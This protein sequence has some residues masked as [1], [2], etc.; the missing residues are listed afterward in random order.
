MDVVVNSKA[1][2]RAIKE[3]IEQRSIQSTRI[4]TVVGKELEA[5][6][7]SEDAPIQ[8]SELMS[9]QFAEQ[10]P[11]VDDPEFIPANIHELGLSSRVISQEVPDSQIEFFYRKLHKLLDITLD[12]ASDQSKDEISESIKS[13][14]FTI[15]E[16]ND[17][18]E[19]DDD[20]PEISDEEYDSYL[21]G[22]GQDPIGDLADDIKE[23]ELR[24][25]Q[26]WIDAGML[27]NTRRSIE[28]N[29]PELFDRTVNP[30]SKVLSL[31]SDSELSEK[32]ASTASSMGNRQET[33]KILA[34]R[35]YL[36]KYPEQ[37]SSAS[38]SSFPPEQVKMNQE[39]DKELRDL[40]K[41][42]TYDE[43][44]ELYN[45]RIANASDP[46]EKKGYEMLQIVVKNK[47]IDARKRR[48][49]DHSVR[50][51]EYELDTGDP[52]HEDLDEPEQV[53]TGYQE[54]EEDRLKALDDM[55]PVFGFK[56]AS[57]IRQWR[58]KYADPKFKALIGSYGGY[59]TYVGFHERVQDNLS[60]LLDVFNDIAQ[61]TLSNLEVAVG[62]NTADTEL[63][64]I[65]NNFE[66]IANEFENMHSASLDSEDGT[67][68]A[69]ALR[70]TAAGIMLKTAF[71][72]LF[73]D[74]MIFRPF[75]N[76]MKKH[77]NEFLI[78]KGLSS[79]AANKFSKMFNGEVDLPPEPGSSSETK[80]SQGLE[81]IG[82]TGQIYKDAVVES[83]KF[84]KDFFT[85]QSKEVDKKFLELI[86][87]KKK[88]I[89]AFEKSLDSAINALEFEEEY[90]IQTSDAERSEMLNSM[91]IDSEESEI[92]DQERE[93]IQKIASYVE[94]ED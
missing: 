21:G 84:T 63:L 12:R 80:K 39:L 40:L 2:E 15:L 29:Y 79:G 91:K 45:E 47:K 90:D 62:K 85:I 74:S 71:G 28:N 92:T 19:D 60:A 3:L 93:I 81:K 16:Q 42:K 78:S 61:K 7:D 14:I 51:G 55:A 27:S 49:H 86:Q 77:M 34:L 6:A 94:D 20:L 89:S 48:R 41:V 57:G 76:L 67:P 88:M 35:K 13:K 4:D 18:V 33:V 75:A 87:N 10:M 65:K 8:P 26:Q 52:E 83:E 38:S 53:T 58:R 73:Y 22:I 59:K 37:I 1:L 43:V 69:E 66:Y 50:I 5:D 36:E 70:V 82:I 9:T 32:I 44:I 11:P 68:S 54:T 31:L 24:I 17:D 64:D 30:T 56:N 72:D 25:I 46:I 23:V